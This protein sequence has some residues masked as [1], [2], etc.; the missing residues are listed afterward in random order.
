M[1]GFEFYE[2][3]KERYGVEAVGDHESCDDRR[4]DCDDGCRRARHR[5]REPLVGLGF[6]WLRRCFRH[7]TSWNTRV[8]G[9]HRTTEVA[10]RFQPGGRYRACVHVGI[11]PWVV[12]RCAV[13]VDSRARTGA[14]VCG[15]VR[16][17][18]GSACKSCMRCQQLRG[19]PCM[20]GGM[21][22]E[23]TTNSPFSPAPRGR[24]LCCCCCSPPLPAR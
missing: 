3:F 8:R 15:P 1:S 22:S 11:D 20:L 10:L 19:A 7:L 23:R 18:S 5:E 24:Y 12:A 17:N 4:S 14:T 21:W 9:H 16:R 6:G 13:C 2:R